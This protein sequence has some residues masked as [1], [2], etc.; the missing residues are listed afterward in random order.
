MFRFS[1]QSQRMKYFKILIF[2]FS[3]F[4]LAQALKS[5]KD[6]EQYFNPLDA[7]QLN[8]VWCRQNDE[9]VVY[10]FMLYDSPYGGS[11]GVMIQRVIDFGVDIVRNEYACKTKRDSI[12]LFDI[13]QNKQRVLTAEILNDTAAIIREQTPDFNF[14]FTIVRK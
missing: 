10:W 4:Q 7:S 8:G 3:L 1:R 2:A 12:F 13:Y 5:C 9:R 11:S 14:Q 6:H